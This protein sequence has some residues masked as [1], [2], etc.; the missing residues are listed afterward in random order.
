MLP[1]AQK[2]GQW[3]TK[4]SNLSANYFQA[5]C[6]SNPTKHL[7][8]LQQLG[9]LRFQFGKG[10]FKGFRNN[11]F[12]RYHTHKI[13]VSSPAWNQMHMQ[14]FCNSGSGST[15]QIK[16]NVQTIAAVNFPQNSLRFSYYLAHIQPCIYFKFVQKAIMSVGPT[17]TWP[18]L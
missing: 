15:A 12:T 4:F 14:M 17:I 7:L 11:P 10:R 1:Q 16:T 5:T 6:L 9:K 2:P 3:A 13:T 18:L 8:A